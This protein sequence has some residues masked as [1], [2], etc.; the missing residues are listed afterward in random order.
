VQDSYTQPEAEE[1]SPPKNLSQTTNPTMFKPRVNPVPTAKPKVISRPVLT[2]PVS[3]YQAQTLSQNNYQPQNEM[4]YNQP[5]QTYHNAEQLSWRDD[6]LK[7]RPL[8]SIVTLNN[9]L[10]LMMV[11]VLPNGPIT[12]VNLAKTY[13]HK[14]VHKVL[15]FPGPLKVPKKGQQADRSGDLVNYFNVELNNPNLT[16]P[17][18]LCLTLLKEYITGRSS[19]IFDKSFIE[20]RESIVNEL[21]QAIFTQDLNKYGEGF[22]DYFYYYDEFLSNTSNFEFQ[23]QSWEDVLFKSLFIRNSSF[24]IDTKNIDFIL[25]YIRSRFSPGDPL[26]NLSVIKL[27]FYHEIFESPF[28]TNNSIHET[29]PFLLYPCIKYFEYIPMSCLKE[30]LNSFALQ[31]MSTK[32]EQ[33]A[34]YIILLSTFLTGDFDTDVMQGATKLS[35]KIEFIQLIESYYYILKYIN[36]NFDKNNNL[37][38]LIIPSLMYY[39]YHLLSYGQYDHAQEY[40]NHIM[41]LRGFLQGLENDSKFIQKLRAFRDFI[42]NHYT[43][44]E[45]SKKPSSQS[46]FTANKQEINDIAQQALQ[47]IQ[48]TGK[49]L[50][51]SIGG[52]FSSLVAGAQDNKS[53]SEQRQQKV[54]EAPKEDFYYDKNLKQWII[55]GQAPT[56]DPDEARRKAIELDDSLPPTKAQVQASQEIPKADN[57]HDMEPPSFKTAQANPFAGGQVGANRGPTATTKRLFQNRYVSQFQ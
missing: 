3:G 24:N 47:K 48:N 17:H 40:L 30:F 54:E 29:W 55:N 12:T 51:K 38:Y 13:L 14:A 8:N 31:I 22:S 42:V 18:R 57:A 9:N 39:G 27:G 2:P 44:I 10:G 16:H 41:S 32:E 28:F 45:E 7:R 21:K 5:K 36:A 50:F 15:T 26:F 25:N 53:K 11:K 33:L 49:G 20:V 37:T 6:P 34:E 23:D 1:T 19:N 35:D 52:A 56:E 4:S 43:L 46:I